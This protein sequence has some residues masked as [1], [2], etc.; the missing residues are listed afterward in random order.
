MIEQGFLEGSNVD[1]GEEM[2]NMI[3][4]QRTF[5]LVSKCMQTS[6]E[7]WGMINSMRR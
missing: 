6:D 7:M 5:Q 3:V 2:V 4:A 1:M